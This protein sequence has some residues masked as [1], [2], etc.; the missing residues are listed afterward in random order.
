MAA[1]KAETAAS[2]SDAAQTQPADCTDTVGSLLRLGARG[3]GSRRRR[4]G[5]RLS[6]GYGRIRLGLL[7]G[8]RPDRS[9]GVGM[10]DHSLGAGGNGPHFGLLVWGESL[11]AATG[12]HEQKSARGAEH[13]AVEQTARGTR[14]A[15]DGHA[16]CDAGSGKKFSAATIISQVP[17]N[18]GS[19]RTGVAGRGSFCR[20]PA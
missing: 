14:G 18:S 20:S 10:R 7:S 19:F 17:R 4:R 11:R 13:V 16:C 8:L 15:V 9:V 5:P 2:R 1:A 12:E 3:S 6:Y